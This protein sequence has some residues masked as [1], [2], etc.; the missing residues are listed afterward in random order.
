MKEQL[1]NAR[2][3]S[4]KHD[5]TDLAPANNLDPEKDITSETPKFIAEYADFYRT[6]RGYHPRSVNSNPMVPGR[7][8]C[9]WASSICPSWNTP[10]KCVRRR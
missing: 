3:E 4:S 2:W 5:Y 1:N 7:R 9:L 8:S 6:S 10:K